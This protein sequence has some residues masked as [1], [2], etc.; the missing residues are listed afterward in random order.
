MR[1]PWR[2]GPSLAGSLLQLSDFGP[3]AF[4]SPN[5]GGDSTAERAACEASFD[6]P[7]PYGESIQFNGGQSYGP[8]MAQGLYISPTPHG[9]ERYLTQ[10]RQAIIDCASYVDPDGYNVTISEIGFA[11]LGDDSVAYHITFEWPDGNTAFEFDRVTI[12]EGLVATVV[13]H[14][15][16]RFT[17]PAALEASATIAVNRLAALPFNQ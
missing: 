12:R 2:C 16:L 17:D 6:F 1:T 5:S 10:T 7:V 8:L 9:A 13:G 15:D 3:G 4:E 14:L 11:N